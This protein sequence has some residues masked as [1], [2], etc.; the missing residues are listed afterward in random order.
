MSRSQAFSVHAR[1]L[2][3]IRDAP[4]S[5]HPTAS[6]ISRSGVRSNLVQM[7]C[8]R[9]RAPCAAV[10]VGAPKGAEGTALMGYSEGGVRW[11]SSDSEGR[12]VKPFFKLKCQKCKRRLA[13]FVKDKGEFFV[14]S[15]AGFSLDPRKVDS[16][17]IAIAI[18]PRCGAETQ[19]DAKLLPGP[20]SSPNFH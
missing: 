19:F 18:C 8:A 2:A 20:A 9:L 1:S 7:T 15:R 11:T 17:G 16:E 5:S 4:V 14:H 3:R 12:D 13:D 6:A 10:L